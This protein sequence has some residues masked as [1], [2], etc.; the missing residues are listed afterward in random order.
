VGRSA[1]LGF[2]LCV[3]GKLS[4][5]ETEKQSGQRFYSSS[6]NSRYATTRTVIFSATSTTTEWIL[7]NYCT[8]LKKRLLTEDPRIRIWMLISLNLYF[9]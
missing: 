2:D 3:W 4:G 6:N 9:G 7:F 1:I 8:F 5:E